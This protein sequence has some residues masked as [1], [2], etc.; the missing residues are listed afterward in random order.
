MAKDFAFATIELSR[1]MEPKKRLWKRTPYE[2][3]MLAME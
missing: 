3:A 2:L 1:N